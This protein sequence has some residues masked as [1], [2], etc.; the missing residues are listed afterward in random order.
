MQPSP[1]PQIVRYAF[2]ERLIHLAAGVTY[3]YSLLTGLAFWSPWLY[4]LAVVLGGGF[5]SRMLHPW[6]GIG[7]MIAVAWMYVLWHRDMATTPEDRVWRRAIGHY[8]RNEDDLMP[9]VGRF[10]YGQ[11]LLFWVMFW[12]G[13]ALLLSGAVLW[14]VATIPP[15][16]RWLRPIAAFVHAAG[17]LVTIGGFIVHV[18]MGVAVVPGG[19]SAIVH[20]PVTEEWARRHHPLW[21]A[22]EQ[23]QARR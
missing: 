17:A 19:L 9:P 21:L 16:L 8:I 1:V 5:V 6:M 12:G 22:R 20:G 18:Y 15:D 11:K 7:F 3:L 14:F 23:R 4:W 2:H 10:N 13:I